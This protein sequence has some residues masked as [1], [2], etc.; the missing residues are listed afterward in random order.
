MNHG[1]WAPNLEANDMTFRLL[2]L[3]GLQIVDFS[4]DPT[5]SGFPKDHW[6]LPTGYFEDQNT[7]ASYRF[8]HPS[9][10]GSKDP[11]GCFFFLF[12]LVGASPPKSL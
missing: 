8:V 11:E 7:L 12:L 5:K 3:E 4:Q 1:L 10:G 9:I 6:T 2:Q